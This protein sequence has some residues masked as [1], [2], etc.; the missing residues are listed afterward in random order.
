MGK[1]FVRFKCHH[2]SHC[3]T[4]VVCLPTPWDVRRIMRETGAEPKD[5]LEF[6]PPDEISDVEADDPTWLDVHGRKYIMALR[7]DGNGCH[8]LDRQTRFCSIYASRPILCRL[9]P[10]AYEEA[11]NGGSPGFS[12]HTDVGC[13]RHRDSVVP[14]APLLELFNEDQRHQQEYQALVRE[15]NEKRYEGKKA[16]DFIRM[17]V[18]C[19]QPASACAQPESTGIP[20][21]QPPQ[22]DGWAAVS[23]P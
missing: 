8:F 16:Q 22:P 3:C 20:R 4:E 21:Q 6:L 10:F 7:R 5:F 23:V 17:V 11:T 15:F 2:C 1:N 13:P 14:V 18:A 12:L 19:N 9:Y